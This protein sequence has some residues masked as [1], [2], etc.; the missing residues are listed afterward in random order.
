MQWALGRPSWLAMGGMLAFIWFCAYCVFKW[1]LKWQHVSFSFEVVDD[2]AAAGIPNASFKF[3]LMSCIYAFINI[4]YFVHLS[5]RCHI[6]PTGWWVI[7]LVLYFWAEQRAFLY[8]QYMHICLFTDFL[9]CIQWMAP[10]CVGDRAGVED[11]IVSVIVSLEHPHR[12][13]FLFQ[14]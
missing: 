13:P 3:H 7:Y 11:P 4:S 14:S 9:I 2:L 1:Q 6:A 5:G 10:W 12:F 8:K